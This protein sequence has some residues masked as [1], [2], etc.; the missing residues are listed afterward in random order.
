[1]DGSDRTK[2][3]LADVETKRREGSVTVVNCVHKEQREKKQKHSFVALTATRYI[4]QT[5]V[6]FL[7]CVLLFR[8]S[9]LPTRAELKFSEVTSEAGVQFKHEDG[10]SGAKYYLEPIGA[11]AAWFDYDRDGDIDIYFVNGADLPGMHSV[12]PPTNALYRNNGDGTFSDVTIQAGVADG[13]YGFSCAVGDFDNDGFPDLYVANFGPNVLYHNNRDGTFTDVTVRAGV[14]DTLWGASAAFADYD[15]DSDLDLYV[16]NYVAF[17]LENNPQCGELNVR[18]YCSPT[19]FEGTPSVLY[20]NNGDGTFTDVTRE[21]GVF[22]PNG[23]GMGIVWCDYDNDH[24]LDLF[25]ANDLEADW[26]YRNQGDGVFT[27]VA[28]FSGVAVD[29]TGSAY[30]SMAPVFGDID[31]DGWFD[32]V[33]TNFSGEP[34]AV[35]RSDRNGLFADITYRSGI[36]A[37]TLMRLSWGA[38]FAD[39]DNDGLVDLFIATGDLND[40]IHLINPNLTYAQQNQLFRNTGNITFEDVSNQSGEGLLLKKV[41]RG[42]AFGDYD[43]DGDIDVI[44]TNCHQPPNLLRN[45]SAHLNHWLSFTTVGVQ[46]NR[47]GIGTRIK[48]VVGGKSQIREVKSGG[49]YPSHSDMRLH[50]GLGQSDMADLVEIR[51]PSGFVERFENVRGNRFLTATEGMGLREQ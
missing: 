38:D 27:E 43:N 19:N 41:S 51:W 40:N 11:G 36:G 10:R 16:A 15:N 3:K 7:I 6:H 37:Q 34:N 28:L 42:A 29:E 13:S 35:Y 24:D 39:F 33:V 5:A 48:V 23:K 9:V 18:T 26:L 31:N 50:F 32:L 14:G 4:L 46:S 49:S 20:Q 30:S 21:A 44:V 12:V 2:S 45:D 17:E 1:M 25:V 22:N 8:C 47:D